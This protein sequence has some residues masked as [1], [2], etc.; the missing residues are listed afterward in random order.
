MDRHSAGEAALDSVEVLL[1]GFESD[2]SKIFWP[3]PER[4]VGIRLCA[5]HPCNAL[6]IP[7]E[8]MEP[9]Q[10]RIKIA[11]CNESLNGSHQE[12]AMC[13]G[14]DAHTALS[15]IGENVC[16]SSLGTRVKMDFGFLDIDEAVSTGRAQGDEHRQYLSD[17]EADVSDVVVTVLPYSNPQLNCRLIS[18]TCNYAKRYTDGL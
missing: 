1:L 12:R 14:H 9:D 2:V 15:R 17:A 8:P 4:A 6:G 3:I 5:A 13:L 16:E 18:P 11:S 10:V 7:G